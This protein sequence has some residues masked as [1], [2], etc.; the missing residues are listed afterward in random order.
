M[1]EPNSNA[2]APSVSVIVVSYNTREMTLECLRSLRE[3]TTLPFELIVVDNASPDG[4]AEAIAS[5]FPDADLIASDENL[6]FARANNIAAKRASAP[7][8][9]LLNPDTVVLDGAVDRLFEF[10]KHE[11]QAMIW[12]GRTLFGDHS[13]N[14]LSCAGKLT[15][16]SNVSRV[17]GLN[18]AFSASEFFNSESYGNWKRDTVRQVDIVSGC[19]FLI[20]RTV[21]EELDG[22]D[23]SFTLYGEETDLCLRA[24][25]LGAKPMVT[26]DATIIHYGGKSS[27]SR[28]NQYIMVQ[29]ARI[30]LARR[31]FRSGFGWLGVFLGRAF[32][33]TRMIGTQIAARL[34]PSPA[35]DEKKNV[36][37]EVWSRRAEWQNGFS[38]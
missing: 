22:F 11:P 34:R 10:S 14:P 33:W 24:A 20:Q 38:G 35:V 25:E 8:L 31:H 4:S 32:P 30:E 9:L 18:R 16:W 27:A 29:K 2:C 13:L 23:E 28:P 17:L 6:G 3:Q 15:I 37:A 36:W 26:P 1:S 7:L 12:G 5:E 19:F 21:W